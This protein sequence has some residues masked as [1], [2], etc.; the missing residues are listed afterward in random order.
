MNLFKKKIKSEWHGFDQLFQMYEQKIPSISGS[1]MEDI[2]K[3]LDDLVESIEDM[4]RFSNAVREKVIRFET[5]P[6]DLDNRR[7]LIMM[8][9]RTYQSVSPMLGLLFQR[10]S[11]LSAHLR[12]FTKESN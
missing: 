1:S 4:R 12:S 8:G 9:N 2:D 11:F 7:S 3:A 10:V 6:I 5:E